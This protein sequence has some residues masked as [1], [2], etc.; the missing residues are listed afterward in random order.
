MFAWGEV[1]LGARDF[2]RGVGLTSHRKPQI[3][4]DFADDIISESIGDIGG[5]V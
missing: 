2:E 3:F 4:V 1:G 5:F